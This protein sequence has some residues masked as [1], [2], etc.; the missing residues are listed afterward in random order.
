MQNPIQNRDLRGL[1]VG[2]AGVAVVGLLAGAAMQPQLK[3]AAGPDG[4]QIM[5]GMSGARTLSYGDPG[6]AFTGYQGAVPDYVLGTDW[7]KTP[8]AVFPDVHFDPEEP[9]IRNFDA[10]EHVLERALERCGG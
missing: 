1:F 3:V 2:A 8:P 9:P 5:A 6:A 4:P 10:D 7:T